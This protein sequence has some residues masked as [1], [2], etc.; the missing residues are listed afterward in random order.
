M[1]FLRFQILAFILKNI[2]V[3]SSIDGNLALPI[4]RFKQLLIISSVMKSCFSLDQRLMPPHKLFEM[5]IDSYLS[6]SLF[7]LPGSLSNFFLQ[8]VIWFVI[9]WLL[10]QKI[11]N[12]VDDI[13]LYQLDL[14]LILLLSYSILISQLLEL[15]NFLLKLRVWALMVKFSVLLVSYRFNAMR[16]LFPPA[17]PFF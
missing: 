5:H 15:K 2:P 4:W 12:F 10:Q 9:R 16:L 13:V 1:N 6:D 8:F 3:F 17:K 14:L 7:I 11:L